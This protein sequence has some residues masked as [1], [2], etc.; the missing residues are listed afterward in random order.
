MTPKDCFGIIVRAVGLLTILAAWY[1]LLGVVVTVGL[2]LL[3]QPSHITDRAVFGTILRSMVVQWVGYYLL[4]GAP[5]LI[6]RAY[7]KRLSPERA[8][9]A[10]EQSASADATRPLLAR[11]RQ[12]CYTSASGGRG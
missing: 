11:L 1:N 12:V 10:V 5:A 4:R 2:D 9:E 3:F 6:E 7:P 8:D